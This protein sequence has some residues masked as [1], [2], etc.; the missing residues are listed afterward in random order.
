MIKKMFLFIQRE[1]EEI[2][3]KTINCWKNFLKLKTSGEWQEEEFEI[4]PFSSAAEIKLFWNN[5]PSLDYAIIVILGKRNQFHKRKNLLGEEMITFAV[6][7]ERIEEHIFYPATK[8]KKSIVIYDTILSDNCFASVDM[9]LKKLQLLDSQ[10]ETND[11]YTD[12]IEKGDLGCIPV[13]PKFFNSENNFLYQTVSL[14]H[15]FD[16]ADSSLITI[17][18]L[19]KRIKKSPLKRIGFICNSGRRLFS[20]PMMYL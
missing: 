13:K 6:Q 19:V 10:I 12:M 1:S 14:Y 5:S 8:S 3:S 7:S 9:Q 16:Y 15:N 20:Y 2:S 18:D 4:I 17:D 11:L